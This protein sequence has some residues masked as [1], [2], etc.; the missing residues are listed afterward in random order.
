MTYLWA[1]LPEDYREAIGSKMGEFVKLYLSVESEKQFNAQVLTRVLSDR[2]RAEAVISTLYEGFDVTSD[3]PIV[4]NVLCAFG[5]AGL[6][7]HPA[8][9]GSFRRIGWEL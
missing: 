5:K 6:L 2:E 8:V 3:L 1:E 7:D 9:R 4:K